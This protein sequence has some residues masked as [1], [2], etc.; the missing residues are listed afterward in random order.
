MTAMVRANCFIVIPETV[1]RVEP[2]DAIGVELL[3]T[4]AAE[5]PAAAPEA[6]GAAA[7]DDCCD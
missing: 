6:A 2:G 4:A 3:D 5:E 7:G 1:A